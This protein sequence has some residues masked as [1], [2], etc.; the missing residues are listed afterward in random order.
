[1]GTRKKILLF[2]VSSSILTLVGAIF[3]LTH[4]TFFANGFMLGGIALGFVFLYFLITYLV[5]SK[6]C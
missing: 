4:I 3:K 1:M 6:E 2:F 5:K